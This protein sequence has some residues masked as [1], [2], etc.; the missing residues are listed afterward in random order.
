[1]FFIVTLRAKA[2]QTCYVPE[3]EQ[4]E[5]RLCSSDLIQ[6]VKKKQGTYNKKVREIN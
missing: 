3:K 1:M 5:E 4:Y 2:M 6:S